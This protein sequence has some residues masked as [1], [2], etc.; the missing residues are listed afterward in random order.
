MTEK[1]KYTLDKDKKVGTMFMGLS[2]A[3]NTLN[4][5]LLLAKL[6]EYGFS[7]SAIKFV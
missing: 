6:K 5:N 7:F 4:H 3:F 2:E 1:W